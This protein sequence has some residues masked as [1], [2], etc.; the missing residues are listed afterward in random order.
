MVL[1]G[2][3]TQQYF[4]KKTTL[5]STF[6]NIEAV[7]LQHY[8]NEAGPVGNLDSQTVAKGE[9]LATTCES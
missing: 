8:K 3:A 7:Q 9:M 2:H 4:P 5:I 6:C 1:V